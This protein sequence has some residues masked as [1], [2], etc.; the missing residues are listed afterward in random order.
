MPPREFRRLKFANGKTQ[1]CWLCGGALIYETAT[2]DHLVPKSC[3]GRNTRENLRL[4]C[5]TCNEM[6]ASSEITLEQWIRLTGRQPPT[7]RDYSALA[8]AIRK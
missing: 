8:N 6:R 1:Y 4:A 2:V 5:R 3:N 7:P